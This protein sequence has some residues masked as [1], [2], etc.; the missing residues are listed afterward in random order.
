MELVEKFSANRRICEAFCCIRLMNTLQKL[1]GPFSGVS[2]RL[3]QLRKIQ[4][5]PSAGDRRWKRS[6]VEKENFE[7]ESV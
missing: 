4:C 1:A 2:D 5:I 3:S 6:F 7:R